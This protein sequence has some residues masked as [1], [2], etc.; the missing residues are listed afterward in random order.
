VRPQL[1]QDLELPGETLILVWSRLWHLSPLLMPSIVAYH[2][3]GPMPTSGYCWNLK[4]YSGWRETNLTF[5][6]DCTVPKKS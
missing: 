4:K 5:F 1:Q 3:Q 2:V 6:F